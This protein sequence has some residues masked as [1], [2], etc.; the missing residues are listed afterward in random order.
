MPEKITNEQIYTKLI[1]IE[2]V[3]RSIKKEEDVIVEEEKEIEREEKV[4]QQEE[5]KI[6]KK[7]KQKVLKYDNILDWKTKIWENCPHK[8]ELVKESEIDYWC[9]KQNAPC[10]Y[11]GCP[12]NEL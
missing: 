7:V 5:K 1:S 2:K 9:K 4:L 8:R 12:L 3:L 6:E 11:M 10:R